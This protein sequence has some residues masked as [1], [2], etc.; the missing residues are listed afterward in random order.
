MALACPLMGG[1]RAAKTRIE[2]SPSR[3]TFVFDKAFVLADFTV[4][5]WT[6]E[7]WTKIWAIENEP[8]VRIR[9]RQVEYGVVPE[10]YKA[11]VP[12]KQ[13]TLT[14][15][16]LY[17]VDY[18]GGPVRGGGIFAL[19][20]RDGKLTVVPLDAGKPEADIIAEFEKLVK[21]P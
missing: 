11:Y 4:L 13:A 5:R 19:V 16:G 14:T 9:V 2:G 1:L 6:G 15:N 12:L 10:G 20:E 17:Q 18:E 3:P 21:A 8:S 7:K